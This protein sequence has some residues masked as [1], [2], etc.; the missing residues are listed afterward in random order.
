MTACM[1]MGIESEENTVSQEASELSQGGDAG[2]S[3]TGCVGSGGCSS[4][5]L[6]A[7]SA[8]WNM[9]LVTEVGDVERG[10]RLARDC[11]IAMV[12]SSSSDEEE[13]QGDSV[14]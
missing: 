11:D 4:T 9:L 6:T 2:D 8:L 13:E 10:G 14:W 1:V 3:G 12:V 5:S 7:D